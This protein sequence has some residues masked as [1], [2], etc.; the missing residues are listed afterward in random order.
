MG[1]LSSGCSSGW[2]AFLV[3]RP[4]R[5]NRTAGLFHDNHGGEQAFPARSARG[6]F[7]QAGTRGSLPLAAAPFPFPVACPRGAPS[8]LASGRCRSGV[9]GSSPAA[10]R[11]P[12]R[13][14]LGCPPQIGKDCTLS[15]DCSQLGDRLCDTSQPDGYCTVFNCE[16][17]SCPNAIC[18]AFQGSLDPA[19]GSAND[20]QWPRLQRTFCLSQCSSPGVPGDCRSD[21]ATSASTCSIPANQI[22]RARRRSSTR[23]RTTA[24][25]ATWSAWST[26][27]RWTPA[28]ASRPAAV[29]APARAGRSA[30]LPPGTATRRAPEDRR[31]QGGSTRG[32]T[33]ATTAPPR[34]RSRP[35]APDGGGPRHVLCSRRRR[36]CPGSCV[37]AVCNPPDAGFPTDGAPRRGRRTRRTRATAASTAPC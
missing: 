33:T 2:A 32:P 1:S 17:D 10:L 16:P 20:G 6:R 23:A 19:C 26:P 22:D 4:G 13:S 3:S 27:P 8:T 36:P 5:V 15:T 11:A 37:P 28:P 14:S 12:P 24:A 21:A 25:S 34:A 29:A 30:V 7:R 31:L 18:V 9:S 35:S